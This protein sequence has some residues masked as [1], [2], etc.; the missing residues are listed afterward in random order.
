MTP[1]T[2][3][4]QRFSYR[5]Y[6]ISDTVIKLRTQCPVAKKVNKK[7]KSVIN[8]NLSIALAVVL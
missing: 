7:V 2:M 8:I 3:S 5:P 1:F 4:M 6:K